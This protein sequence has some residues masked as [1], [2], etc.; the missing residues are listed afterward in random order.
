MSTPH[1]DGT[2]W[3]HVRDLNVSAW[4]AWV[5]RYSSG[6]SPDNVADFLASA[7]G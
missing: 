7:D 3:E 5:N 6:K 2:R 4:R 1:V